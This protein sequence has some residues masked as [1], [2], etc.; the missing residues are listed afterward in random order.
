VIPIWVLSVCLIGLYS[1][2]PRVELPVD[3]W[4]ADKVY[5]FIAYS[6][7]GVLPIIG[8]ASRKVGATASLSM[9]IVGLS[10]EIGQSYVPGRVFSFVDMGANSLGVVVGMICGKALRARLGIDA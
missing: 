2:I 10:L 3:F 6:W 7:L 4:N 9:V 8:F 1:L 5:H